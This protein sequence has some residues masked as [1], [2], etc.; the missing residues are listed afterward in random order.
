MESTAQYW[1]PVWMELEGAFRLHLAQAQSNRAPHGRKSDFADAWRLLRRF[2][3]HELKLSFVPDPE[4]RNWRDLTHT[5]WE[6]IRSK[7]ALHNHIEILLERAQIKLTSLI[8]DVLGVSGRRVLEALAQGV[9]EP[10]ELAA[11]ADRRIR[12]S[13]EELRDALTGRLADE[14]PFILRLYLQQLSL[15]DR[16]LEAL[17]QQIAEC[18]KLQQ[19]AIERLCEI[20][21]T[22]LD[23]AHQ[24]IAE[25]GPDAEA[26]PSAA[27][28]AS[29]VGVPVPGFTRVRVNPPVTP[30]PSAIVLCG[31]S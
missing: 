6:L 21:G 8:S 27:Q 13:K 20:P 3:A 2:Y 7:V 26:F 28:A 17:D 5:R 12:A 19:A 29:W 16:Q 14:Q 9:S 1:R 10:A 18:L 30:P 22:S 4:Q 23:A 25:L 15:L 31:A 11:L 24:I